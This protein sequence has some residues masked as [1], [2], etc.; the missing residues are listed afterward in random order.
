MPLSAPVARR[1]RHTRRIEL[2]GYQR[3]DGLWDIEAHLIDTKGYEFP[4]RFRGRIA[5]GE[6]L[7]E[8][9]LRL[10]VDDGLVIRA[11]EAVTDHSPFPECPRAAPNYQALVGL[12][13]GSGW[14]D[15]V[16]QR[17]PST[18]GCTHLFELLRPLAT[19]AIQTIMPLRR[20]D[21]PTGT[22]R[23]AL[24]DTCLGWRADGEAVAAIYPDWHR[25]GD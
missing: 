4:N 8:M 13:I 18:S 20:K 5:V 6:A 15:R 1:H 16:K 2:N 14:T 21:D 11:V 22:R 23:P 7:H 9:W 10:T 17:M 3:E 12:Q 24:I 19:A 25:K